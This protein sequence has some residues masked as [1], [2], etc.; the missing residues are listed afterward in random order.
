MGWMFWRVGANAGWSGGWRGEGG[1]RVGCGG[2]GV[3]GCSEVVA[4]GTSTRG[5]EGM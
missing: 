2:I 5:R 4:K 3:L 1:V